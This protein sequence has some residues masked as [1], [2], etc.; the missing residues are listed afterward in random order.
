[1]QGGW[2]LKLTHADAVLAMSLALSPSTNFIVH[3][4]FCLT[5]LNKVFSTAN[6]L[7]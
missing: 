2:Y 7:F 3:F 6:F 4:Q 1:M 5:I